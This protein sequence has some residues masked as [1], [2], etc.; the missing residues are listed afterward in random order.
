M[1]I[2]S[3]CKNC[4]GALH[5]RI[6]SL[7]NCEV[8]CYSKKGESLSFKY[9]K[10]IVNILDFL[11]NI[12][13]FCAV[14]IVEYVYFFILYFF[15][16]TT[17]TQVGSQA[18]TIPAPSEARIL[19]A[20]KAETQTPRQSPPVPPV[21]DMAKRRKIQPKAIILPVLALALLGGGGYWGWVK[22]QHTLYY[23]TTDNAQIEAT[24]MPVLARVAGYVKDV[25]VSDYKRVAANDILLTIDD[26]EYAIALRQA[27]ADVKQAEADV[28]NARAALKNARLN[29]TH[30]RTNDDVANMSVPLY[31]GG[32]DRA[33][34]EIALASLEA[35]RTN[36]DGLKESLRRDMSNALADLRTASEK[37]SNAESLVRQAHYGYELAESRYK[38][39]VLTSLDLQS[40]QAGMLEANLSKLQQEYQRCLAGLELKRIAGVEYWTN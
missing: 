33:Q 9:T 38:N 29:S 21:A 5:E 6:L 13:Y 37:L 22:L 15:R 10:I 25:K 23:E 39:G 34:Y 30:A 7:L 14:K 1:N 18:A 11:V 32:R 16:T 24:A 40:A 36:A 27:E 17:S 3:Q 19:S 26:A 20:A 4:R 31:V 12:I 35:S 8:P 28:D 2:V